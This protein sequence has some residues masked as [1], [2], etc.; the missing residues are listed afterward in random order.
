MD[1][2][3]KV[4]VRIRPLLEFERGEQN[5]NCI[6]STPGEPQVLFAYFLNWI[7]LYRYVC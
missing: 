1:T 6:K 5:S 7:D 4:G 2:T 3:V